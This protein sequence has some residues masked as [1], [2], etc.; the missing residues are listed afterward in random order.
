MKTNLADADIFK[1]SFLAER[2]PGEFSRTDQ[3]K[4]HG[5]LKFENV[6][7]CSYKISRLKFETTNERSKFCFYKISC[8]KKL[9]NGKK[10]NLRKNLL[11]IS[12]LV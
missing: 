4:V 1:E 11:F 9:I 6:N 5:L 8:L 12:S 10:I 3:S 7:L 2:G